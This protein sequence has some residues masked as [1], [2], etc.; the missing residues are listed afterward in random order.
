MLMAGNV[1]SAMSD[2]GLKSFESRLAQIDK[3]HAAGGAFEATGALGRAYFDSVR[4]KPRKHL[5]LRAIALLFFGAL[6]FKGAL[7]AQIGAEAYDTRVATLAS[8]SMVEQI[9][10]WVLKAD[11]AT[12]VIGGLIHAILF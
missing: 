12:Q 11:P 7:F 6:L 9:G 8:G 4:P 3:I 5:P 2:Q 1:E 10:G